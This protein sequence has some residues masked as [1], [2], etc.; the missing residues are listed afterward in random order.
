M[1][2]YRMAGAKLQAGRLQK[3]VRAEL[4]GVSFASWRT[5]AF[6]ASVVK[7]YFEHLQYYGTYIQAYSVVPGC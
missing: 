3:V 1:Y 4:C 5:L 2:N 7:D 6:Q